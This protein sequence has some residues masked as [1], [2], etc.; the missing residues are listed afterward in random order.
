M[1]F[2]LLKMWLE[3]VLHILGIPVFGHRLIMTFAPSLFAL[4]ITA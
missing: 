3:Q 4:R 1:G 2:G